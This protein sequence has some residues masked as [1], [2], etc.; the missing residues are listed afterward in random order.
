MIT[1]QQVNQM[2]MAS[3]QAHA[4]APMPLG[5]AQAQP[6]GGMSQYPPTFSYGM[7]GYQNPNSQISNRMVGAGIGAAQG[8]LGAAGTVNMVAGLGAMGMGLMGFTPPGMLA[9]A[10]GLTLGAGIMAAGAPVA[11]MAAGF[12]NQQQVNQIFGNQQFAN[13]NNPYGRGFSR[14]DLNRMYGAVRAIDR[15]DPFVSMSDA[16]RVTQRF[17][18]EFGMQQGVKDAEELAKRVTGLGKT[19]A[20]MAKV[21]GTTID[22]AGEMMGR[23]RGAGFYTASDVMGNTQSYMM[24]RNLGFTSGQTG[25]I[26]QQGAD[27]SRGMGLSGRAG[28][29]FASGMTQDL[30]LMMRMGNLSEN[31]LMDATGTTTRNDAAAAF[32]Q[33]MQGMLQQ[34][35]QGAY[36]QAFLSGLMQTGADGQVSINTGLLE[37]MKSGRVGIDEL[38]R[39][40]QQNLSSQQGRET[41]VTN[42]DQLLGQFMES[43]DALAGLMQVIKTEAER[44]GKDPQIL[45]QQIAGINSRDYRLMEEAVGNFQETRRERIRTATLELQTQ[46]QQRMMRE[47]GTF[48]GLTQQITGGISDALIAPAVDVGANV[49]SAMGQSLDDARMGALRAIG[50]GS[51]TFNIS[52]SMSDEVSNAMVSQML[53][54]STDRYSGG[55]MTAINDGG[56]GSGLTDRDRMTLAS[57]TGDTAEL[58]RQLGSNEAAAAKLDSSTK[59]E[60]RKKL[61]LAQRTEDPKERKRLLDE[62]RLMSAGFGSAMTAIASGRVQANMNKFLSPGLSYVYGAQSTSMLNEDMREAGDQVLVAVGGEDALAAIASVRR[63]D[64]VTGAVSRYESIK[65]AQQEMSALIPR[66]TAETALTIT[67]YTGGLG[68]LAISSVVGHMS[69]AGALREGLKEGKGAALMAKATTPAGMFRIDKIIAKAQQTAAGDPSKAR[70]LAAKKLSSVLG[71]EVS[72]EDVSM[73]EGLT[74]RISSVA[75]AD[76]AAGGLESYKEYAGTMEVAGKAAGIAYQ[77]T[78]EANA[79]SLKK[80]STGLVSDLRDLGIAGEDIMMGIEAFAEGEVGGGAAAM[81]GMA[82]LIKRMAA[83]GVTSGDVAGK[84]DFIKMAQRQSSELKRIQDMV[85]KGMTAAQLINELGV[86][87]S[88]SLAKDILQRA[89]G[90]ALSREDVTDIVSAA[91]AGGLMGIAGA[92]AGALST[93]LR[94]GMTPE[95]LHVEQLQKTAQMIDALYA[96]MSGEEA[97]FP[98]SAVNKAV[99]AP[100]ID[101]DG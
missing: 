45:A 50:R 63:D 83:E 76:R 81:T 42:R 70:E 1:S 54:T 40:S 77:Q 49:T 79:Q 93:A 78:V 35:G 87:P 101:P 65:K 48:G 96:K 71:I 88:S 20:E 2:H 26:Q 8:V 39:V 23:M 57:R 29:T 32:A 41:F 75:P 6:M 16:L 4:M 94:A 60:I 58:G 62:A 19:L 18:T 52:G 43:D 67:K 90:G 34:T 38:R 47:S 36:G 92:G 85:G 15:D 64:S 56:A 27:M 74:E 80:V 95:E 82:D 89:S 73:Y 61:R 44:A 86:D 91:G 53:G 97:V 68:G 28:A 14:M 100:V 22:E 30:A 99:N 17:G 11:A 3:M 84:S 51:A 12:Q 25:Q 98:D 21:M 66:T 9:A 55:L 72:S 31:A 10:G 24:G 37:Q 46:Q 7:Q 69:G 5:M 59:D 33:R 13:P